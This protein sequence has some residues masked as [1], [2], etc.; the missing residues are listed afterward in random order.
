MSGSGPGGP[1]GLET[2]V[3]KLIPLLFAVLLVL[4]VVNLGR[5]S[6][7]VLKAEFAGYLV[8]HAWEQALADGAAQ[9]QSYKPWPWADTWPVARLSIP[10][11]ALDQ[12]VLAGQS[13]QALAFAPGMV[14]VESGTTDGE[15][16]V[17]SAH[18]DTHF[19]RLDQLNA[20]DAVYLQ[21]PGGGYLHYR[22]EEKKVINARGSRWV[23]PDSG[24]YLV[25]ATCYPV[26][27]Y[28]P[29][30]KQRLLVI[31]KQAVPL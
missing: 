17:I 21:Q 27:G 30:P 6:W 26:D 19:S 14:H 10:V 29:D 28:A 4:A 16:R 23:A 13:G 20:G 18:R 24:S 31:A 5:S 12:T 9:A 2:P 22:I 8:S 25:L 11:I 3:A 1:D 15:L 7:I